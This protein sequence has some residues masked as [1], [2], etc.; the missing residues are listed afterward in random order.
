MLWLKTSHGVAAKLSTRAPVIPR[1]DWGRKISFQDQSSGCWRWL[2]SSSRVVRPRNSVLHQ[3]GLSTGMCS[4]WT[5]ASPSGS[6]LRHR[7]RQTDRQ[8][9][10]KVEAAVFLSSNLRNDTPP[11]LPFS[12]HSKRVPRSCPHASEG[13]YTM[14]RTTELRGWGARAG[15]AQRPPT[16]GSIYAFMISLASAPPLCI[17]A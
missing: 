4:A 7:E 10:P 1:H 6:E 14:A 2:F 17:T 12:M 15:G 5:F 3:V 16:T 11:L 13:D 9:R 8:R